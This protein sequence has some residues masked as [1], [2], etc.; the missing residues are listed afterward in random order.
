MAVGLPSI[1]ASEPGPDRGDVPPRRQ[2]PAWIAISAVRQLR[3]FA[4]PILVLVASRGRDGDTRMLVPLIVLALASVVWQAVAWRFLSYAVEGGRLKVQSGVFARRERFVPVERI[5]AVDL[6]ETPLQRLFGVVGVRIETAAGGSGQADV[7]L[8]AVSRADAEA[9]RR[10]LLRD[11][12]RVTAGAT[13]EVAPGGTRLGTESTAEGGELLRRLSPRDVLVAGATAGRI[14]PALAAVS[15]GFQFLDDL[16]PES[17][18]R[19]LT[20]QAPGYG[21]RGL[22]LAV[23]VGAVVAWG[24]SIAG[25][26]LTWSNF[27]LRRDGDRLLIAHGLLDRRRRS[28]PL[29]RLQAVAV[30]E[31][32]LRR[33]FGLAEVRFESAGFAGASGEAGV[34]VPLLPLAEARAFVTAATP[35]FSPPSVPALSA[36]PPRAR[37]RYLGDALRPMVGLLAVALV[38]A[39]LLPAVRWWWGAAVLVLFPLAVWDGLLAFREAGW[40]I[41]D[42]RFILREGGLSRRTIVAPVRRLQWRTVVQ[43]PFARR[44]QLATTEAAVASGGEGGSLRLRHLDEGVA[45]GLLALLASPPR[46]DDARPHPPDSASVPQSPGFGGAADEAAP[47]AGYT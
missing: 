39:A 16:L 35:G 33:L 23:A 9:L 4:V 29:T 3:G 36:P 42:G 7:V 21:V 15:F 11:P 46:S 40:T 8:P 22:V 47:A 6:G 17:A 14:G 20:L 25:A 31:S 18:W 32:P 37:G 13:A 44:A 2:H 26:V 19:A 27:E 12:G 24:L 30:G 45:F 41:D 1:A 28:V 5:Q 43:T 10:R 34:L 38:A